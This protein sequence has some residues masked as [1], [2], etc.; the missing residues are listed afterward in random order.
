ML[1]KSDSSLLLVSMPVSRWK[2]MPQ[3]TPYSY[4]GIVRSRNLLEPPTNPSRRA[5][6]KVELES[7]RT[8]YSTLRVNRYSGLLSELPAI[9][10]LEDSDEEIILP[11]YNDNSML[12]PNIQLVSIPCR[13]YINCAI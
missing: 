6:S 7:G 9:E 8:G 2:A 4:V 11:R 5:S 13:R 10:V 3:R 12:Q 1:Y